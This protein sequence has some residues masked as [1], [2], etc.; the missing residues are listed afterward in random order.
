MDDDL[1]RQL[2]SVER[3]NEASHPRAWEDVVAGTRTAEEARALSEGLSDDTLDR[4]ADLF[5]PMGEEETAALVDTLQAA[6][7]RGEDGDGAGADEGA[8]AESGRPSGDAPAG[9]FVVDGGRKGEPERDRK[10]RPARSPTPL[11]PAS[12]SPSV[13]PSGRAWMTAVAGLVAVAAAF[14]LYLRPADPQAPEGSD[15]AVSPFSLV[16]RNETLRFDRSAAEEGDPGA[17]ARYRG[18]SRIHWLLSPDEALSSADARALRIRAW[19]SPDDA[20]EPPRAVNLDRAL[21]ISDSGVVELR[22][23]FGDLFALPAGPWTIEIAIAV[24][25]LPETLEQARGEGAP[26]GAMLLP[27]YAVEVID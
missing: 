24:G 20:D 14:A 7:A 26:E 25:E 2:G 22:G 10:V 4:Y 13:R 15:T 18:D 6:L 1:L 8:E 11:P 9:L 3:E 17:P 16:V 19:A 21:S 12:D 27:G 23:T 5:R